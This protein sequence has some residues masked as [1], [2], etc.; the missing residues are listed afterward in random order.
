LSIA[1]RFAGRFVRPPAVHHLGGLVP[2]RDLEGDV[3]GDDRVGYVSQ[4]AGLVI[5]PFFSPL[6]RGDVADNVHRAAR[7]PV[8]V[9]HR[10]DGDRYPP[11]FSGQFQ[12][13][14][15]ALPL[16]GVEHPL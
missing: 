1:A 6:A 3:G 12:F 11:S 10:I 15:D 2:A 7:A 4:Q 9:D 8:S 13:Q 5:K 16:A 14:L